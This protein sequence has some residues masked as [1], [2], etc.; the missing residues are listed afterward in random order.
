MVSFSVYFVSLLLLPLTQSQEVIDG[1]WTDDFL[2]DPDKLDGWYFSNNAI[3][4]LGNP[5]VNGLTYK[6]HG[7]FT[8][9][10][11]LNDGKFNHMIRRF[12]CKRNSD[13]FLS[14]AYGYCD[15]ADDNDFV[16]L[17][18]DG[19][20]WGGKHSKFRIGFKMNCVSI[21][22][23]ILERNTIGCVMYYDLLRIYTVFT[24]EFD[25]YLS[26]ANMD[27]K[28]NKEGESQANKEGES[29]QNGVNKY[30]Q[31]VLIEDEIVEIQ[32]QQ[33]I[34]PSNMVAIQFD[35]DT[36]AFGVY[37]VEKRGDWSY[38]TPGEYGLDASPFIYS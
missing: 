18:I 2:H 17:L 12:S 15:K 10:G 3:G 21:S 16:K 36:G 26:C 37:N 25:D 27:G 22:W 8:K 20:Q 4:S 24:L 14:F 11:T 19:V 33:D 28:G 35:V 38:L 23:N 9:N 32:T 30:T 34:F 7:P 29:L 13:L 5:I 1:T 6:Y 31:S